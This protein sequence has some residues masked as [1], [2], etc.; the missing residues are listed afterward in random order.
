MLLS[1]LHSV[2][3]ATHDE[4]Q[5][6]ALPCQLSQSTHSQINPELCLIGKSRFFH[7]SNKNGFFS[8]GIK[9]QM[10]TLPP[11]PQPKKKKKTT[12]HLTFLHW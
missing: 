11:L 4:R 6:L 7:V 1:P 10:P 3:D 2:W 12:S 5:A 9:I 8:L